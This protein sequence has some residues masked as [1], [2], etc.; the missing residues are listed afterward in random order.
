MFTALRPWKLF[1]DDGYFGRRHFEPHEAMIRVE[2]KK[3]FDV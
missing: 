3:D 1:A 2:E